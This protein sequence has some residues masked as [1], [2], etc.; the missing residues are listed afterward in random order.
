MLLCMT[1]YQEGDLGAAYND[2]MQRLHEGDWACFIDHDAMW[3][4]GTWHK[5]LLDAISLHKQMGAFTCVTNRSATLWQC[6]DAQRSNHDV[7]Y[8]REIGA[9]L[10]ARYWADVVDV[11][12]ESPLSGHCIIISKAMWEHV[13]E[14]HGFLGMD[15]EIHYAVARAGKRVGLLK[16]VYVYH[17]YRALE[18]SGWLHLNDP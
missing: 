16:G 9:D 14:L 7:K 6:A 4:T 17:W 10:A 12:D 1:P 15:N 11:T 13:P 2:A 3:T 5:Q 18:K 8:H